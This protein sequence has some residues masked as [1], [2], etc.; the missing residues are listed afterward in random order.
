MEENKYLYISYTTV[1]LKIL[2]VDTKQKKNIKIL[3]C[4]K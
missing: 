2:V 3:T 1:L 4:L